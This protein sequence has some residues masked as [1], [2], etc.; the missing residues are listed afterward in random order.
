MNEPLIAGIKKWIK[1]TKMIGKKVFISSTCFDLKDLRAELAK[2]LKEWGYMP[3]WNESPNFPKKHGLHSH[4]TCIDAVKECD[5]YLLIIDKR[6]G[7]TYAGNKYPKQ[8]ISITWYE[9]KI[10]LQE[11]KEIHTFVR[12]EAWNERPTYKKNLGEGIKIKPHHVDNPKVFKFIDFL[13]HQPRDNWIDT[14]KDSV[15]LKDKLRIMLTASIERKT[16]RPPYSF[17]IT[18]PEPN[19]VGRQEILDTITKWYRN[20]DVHIGALIG[21]GGEGKSAIVRKWYDNLEDYS[22]KPEGIFWWGFYHNP[23][24]ERF[25]DSLLDYFA[26][27][28]IDLKEI[29]SNWAKVDKIKEFVVEGDYLIILDGLEGMQKGEEYGEKFGCMT[30]REIM[31]ILI[32]LSDSKAKGLCLITTRYP[33]TDINKWGKKTFQKKEVENLSIEDARLLFEKIGVKGSQD[34]IDATIKEFNGHALS[35][36]LLANYLVKD[37]KGDIERA[38]DIPPFHSDKEAGGKSHRMLL[39]YAKQLKEEQLAFMKI[40][41]LFRR[42]VNENDFEGVFRSEMETSINKPLRDTNLFS[43]KRMIDNLCDRKLTTKRQDDTYTTH[44]LVKNYFE[45]IFEEQDKKLC[46]KRI[47]QYLGENGLEKPEIPEI[48]EGMMIGI[49]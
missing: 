9:T 13:V 40:F 47:Y 36:T 24:L 21:W 29:K 35:L 17:N 26:A 37:F 11:N 44:P 31:E 30:H 45:S 7:G 14:F 5:I 49:I 22:I 27:G 6:Y 46:H 1:E 4:D 25:L 8:D 42:E 33:L 48:P 39:W 2:A 19:F 20:S 38:K 43:F 18:Y 32:S 23:Y 41:S 34:D 10:A 16:L 12:D 28:R 15:D 3:I